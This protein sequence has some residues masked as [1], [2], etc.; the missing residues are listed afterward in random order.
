VPAAIKLLVFTG[1]RLGEILGLRREWIDFER[2]EH[3]LPDSK[4]GRKQ[5]ALEVLLE[6][7]RLQSNSHVIVGGK[8]GEA[9]ANLQK[10]SRA[11]RKQAGLENVR[12]HDLRHAFASVVS[13]R[14]TLLAL[15]ELVGGGGI[16]GVI[17]GLVTWVDGA[18][19]TKRT[20]NE[21]IRGSR[22]EPRGA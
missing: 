12:L 18:G 15:K 14:G 21:A 13:I 4:T 19:Q 16:A 6:L 10:P 8:A 11:I 7:P 3:R 2:G 22:R 9:L 5:S 1:A 20:G 17:N